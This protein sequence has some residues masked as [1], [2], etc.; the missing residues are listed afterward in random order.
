VTW[1]AET[2]TD[3]A[4]G[5]VVERTDRVPERA[6]I[7]A[8]LPRFTGA[9]QQVPPRFSAIKIQGERAYDLAREGEAVELS[10]RPVEIH[11]LSLVAMPDADHAVFEA[12]CGKGRHADLDRALL[13]HRAG[14]LDRDPGRLRALARLLGRR[15]MVEAFWT[16]NAAHDVARSANDRRSTSLNEWARPTD[17]VPANRCR[18]VTI[19]AR[20]TSSS[21]M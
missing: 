3:D 6:E 11:R 9:V 21:G 20:V 17:G 2:N 15:G 8:L 18:N 10:P 4:E 7:E 13:Q 1:G 16:W 12:E 14:I 5:E 19:W